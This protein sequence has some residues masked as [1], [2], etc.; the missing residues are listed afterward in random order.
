MSSE[1]DTKIKNVMRLVH[2]MGVVAEVYLGETG[3]SLPLD[4]LPFE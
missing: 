1:N 3:L 4:M 2:Q